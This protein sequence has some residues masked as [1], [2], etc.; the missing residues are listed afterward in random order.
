MMRGLSL[1][2]GY[3]GIDLALKDYVKPIAYVEIEPYAQK[4]IAYRMA[5]G[6]LP[7]AAILGDVQNIEGSVGDCDI[8]YGG[9]PCQDLSVA[10]NGA[11]LEGKRSGLF[12]EVVR[13]AKEI[14]PSFIFLENVPAIRTRGLED[15]V[16]ALTEIRYD[17]RW[18]CI[19][20]S[21]VGANHKRERWFLLAHTNRTELREQQR[22]GCWPD[23]SGKIEFDL[24][25]ET[26]SVADTTIKR[27]AGTESL[28]EGNSERELSGNGDCKGLVADPESA[29]L[30]RYWDI[31]EYRT[32][33][34]QEYTVFTDSS[35]EGGEDWWSVEPPILRVVNGTA[36]QLDDVIPATKEFRKERIK[37]AGNGVVPLQVRVA[38]EKLLGIE[39]YLLNAEEIL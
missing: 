15:V 13:L 32:K 27:L 12:Y 23:R 7:R 37:A 22:R 17:C 30:E 10:G 36:D 26:Q 31:R 9:F 24:D 8:I 34:R 20:A 29:R 11:G 39:N 33:K 4:I 3:G 2:T 19:S 18:L 14:Q 25:G 16:R 6:S 38:F 28:G 1:F 21:D 5:D 35:I